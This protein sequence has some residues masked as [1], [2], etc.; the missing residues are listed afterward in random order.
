MRG[1]HSSVFLRDKPYVVHFALS[2][3]T[4]CPWRHRP[5]RS[6][7]SGATG[8]LRLELTALD[9][10]SARPA[11][12]ATTLEPTLLIRTL[13][14]L[15]LQAFIP[16]SPPR[17]LTCLSKMIRF[18]RGHKQKASHSSPVSVR[19]F[20]SPQEMPIQHLA[21]REPVPKPYGPQR[22][23]GPKGRSRA[24]AQRRRGGLRGENTAPS[25]QFSATAWSSRKRVTQKSP[26]EV[27]ISSLTLAT[28]MTRSKTPW[29]LCASA[30]DS[31]VPDGEVRL[32]KRIPFRMTSR[33]LPT[34]RT[35]R[36]GRPLSGSPFDPVAQPDGITRKPLLFA[37]ISWPEPRG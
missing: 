37:S 22:E 28:P 19:A 25:E 21:R 35:K 32:G 8:P 31:P 12:S 6:S 15:P 9:S 2:N 26:K 24:E 33:Y 10:R 17:L 29:R 16:R 27:L 3:T 5:D 20:R 36:K 1:A 4:S 30:R 18:Q 13:I 34:A 7:A 23:P 11:R 14:H